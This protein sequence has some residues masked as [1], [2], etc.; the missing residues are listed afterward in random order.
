MNNAFTKKQLTGI[1]IHGLWI[2]PSQKLLTAPTE[3]D[4][5]CL[6]YSYC[7]AYDPLF[8]SVIMGK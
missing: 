8:L 7:L 1:T 2:K 4:S 5:A 6:S 3:I